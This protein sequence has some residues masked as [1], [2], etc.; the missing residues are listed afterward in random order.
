[1][2]SAFAASA[3]LLSAPMPALLADAM[4]ELGQKPPGAMS[5]AMSGL[6][7]NGRPICAF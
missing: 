3:S 2:I 5:G 4:S 1:M 6:P 7:E